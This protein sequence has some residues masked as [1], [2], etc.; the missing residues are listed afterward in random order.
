MISLISFNK[1]IIITLLFKC[2]KD[3]F[4]RYNIVHN[5]WISMCEGQKSKCNLKVTGKHCKI[6]WY[7][8]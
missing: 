4:Y 7:H 2:I 8:L 5:S 6:I 3:M 1:N